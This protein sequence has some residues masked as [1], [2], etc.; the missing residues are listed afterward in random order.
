MS[1]LLPSDQTDLLFSS[2]LNHLK[3]FIKDNTDKISALELKK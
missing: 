2:V 3:G 1:K